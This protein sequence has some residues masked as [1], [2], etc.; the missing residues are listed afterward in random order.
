MRDLHKI[1]LDDEGYKG[2]G[3]LYPEAYKF[4]GVDP[5][6]GAI[7]IVRPDQYVS[8]VV[9]LDDYE[10]IGT[11]FDGFLIPRDSQRYARL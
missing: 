4:Y 5:D 11:F 10:E 2:Y 6:V 7:A 9:G 3:M 8:K 1:F